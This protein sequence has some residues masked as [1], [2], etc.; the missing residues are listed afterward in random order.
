[1]K[2][3]VYAIW[4][5]IPFP[6]EDFFVLSLDFPLILGK[7]ICDFGDRI[8]LSLSKTNSP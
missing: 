4:N 3:K 8:S 1:M 5:Y 7:I 2:Q 6:C